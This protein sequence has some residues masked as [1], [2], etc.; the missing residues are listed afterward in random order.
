[1]HL[2]NPQSKC[3]KKKG[4]EQIKCLK[5]WQKK[6]RLKNGQLDQK[7]FCES[8][9]QGR[10]TSCVK[11]KSWTLFVFLKEIRLSDTF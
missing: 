1:M 3:E 5:F 11:Q 2:S 10:F 6:Q 7:H 4:I 9:L 8:V